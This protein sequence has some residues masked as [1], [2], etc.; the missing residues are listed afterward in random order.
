M[1]II[2]HRRNTKNL[3]DKTKLKYGLEIDIRSNSN[4]LILSH[5]PYINAQSFDEWHKHYNHKFLVLNIKEEG[6][7]EKI[8]YLMN[9]YNIEDFFVLDQSFPFLIKTI[10]QGESRVSVRLS[11]YESINTL[12]NLSEKVDWVWVDYFTKF[13]LDKSQYEILKKVGFRVCI[14]SPELQG[15]PIEEL[16]TLKKYLQNSNIIAD[17]VCTKY[18]DLWL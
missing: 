9:K 3:L 10:N 15:F 7:E 17:A 2:H 12:L 4:D 6:L 11:E 1:L 13:P 18:P 8:F 14:V 5:D 16:L